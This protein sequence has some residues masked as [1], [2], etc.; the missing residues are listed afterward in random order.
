MTEVILDSDIRPQVVFLALSV[1]C[2]E[3]A[4]AAKNEKQRMYYI[5]AAK[6]YADASELIDKILED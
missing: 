3:S 2:I 5:G 4:K 6:A 1:S